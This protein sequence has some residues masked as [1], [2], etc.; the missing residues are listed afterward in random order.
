MTAPVDSLEGEKRVLSCGSA[1]N[2]WSLIISNIHARSEHHAYEI[3]SFLESNEYKNVGSSALSQGE[4]WLE[5]MLEELVCEGGNRSTHLWTG[6]FIFTEK[7]AV[8]AT[9]TWDHLQQLSRF[10]WQSYELQ[11]GE[12]PNVRL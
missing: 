4:G 11:G 5:C 6:F 7:S 10:L 8:E 12:A 1:A 3:M 9:L 2:L